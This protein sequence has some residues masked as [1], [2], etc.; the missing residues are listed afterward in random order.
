LNS[1]QFER[2]ASQAGQNVIVE[3]AR[4]DFA[5][6]LRNC[7]L[8]VSQAGYNTVMETLQAGARAVLVPFAGGA[9]SEQTLRA[10]LLAERGLVHVVEEDFLTATTLA[11]AVDRAAAGARP[12]P[13]AVDLGGAR[14]SAELLR[15]WVA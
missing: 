15:E 12:A 10:R 9:E 1:D 8:S 5:L 6:R 2:L 14:R 13:G 3:R 7:V 11:A 4:N